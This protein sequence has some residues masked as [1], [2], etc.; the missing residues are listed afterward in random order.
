MD[1]LQWK[2]EYSVGVESVDHEHRKMIALINEL[3]AQISEHVDTEQV[4]MVLGEIYAGIDA[5]FALEER[6]MRNANYVE[7]TAHKRDHEALLDELAGIM[8]Q[9]VLDPVAGA[10]DLATRLSAWFKVHFS[11]FDARLH[12]TLGDPPES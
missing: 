9:F 3:S 11:S 10:R 5:H 12:G 8:D 6:F 4:E 7:Y 1:L 2:S